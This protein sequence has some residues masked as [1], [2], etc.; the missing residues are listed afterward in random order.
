VLDG[1]IEVSKQGR[2]F[3]VAPGIFIGEIGFLLDETASATVRLAQG[4]RYIEWSR[5]QLAG[6]LEKYPALKAALGARLNSFD[7]RLG[8]N[9]PLTPFIARQTYRLFE[10]TDAR[11]F[12]TVGDL[13]GI[14]ARWRVDPETAA[15]RSSTANPRLGLEPMGKGPPSA[16]LPSPV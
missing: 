8:R 13:F 5:G 6:L 15:K 4:A 9:H 16:F 14:A 1:G 7:R 11:A 2:S 3:S 10:G 12:C